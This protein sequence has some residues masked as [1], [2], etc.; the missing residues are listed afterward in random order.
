[1]RWCTA[2]G[3]LRCRAAAR[4]VMMAMRGFRSLP[5]RQDPQTGLNRFFKSQ[6]DV[7][8]L[9]QTRSTCS[10]SM[11]AAM[12]LWSFRFC[13]SDVALQI[14]PALAGG[15]EAL[16]LALTIFSGRRG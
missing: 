6:A 15:W 13:L 8:L 12:L 9:G 2:E 4:S 14:R 5:D 3:Y 16:D 11:A 1:M 10:R 7:P